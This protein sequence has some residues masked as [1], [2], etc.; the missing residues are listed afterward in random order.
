MS[1]RAG[2]PAR[3]SPSTAPAVW[4]GAADC[5]ALIS[6]TGCG[7]A[8]WLCRWDRPGSERERLR[9]HRVRKAGHGDARNDLFPSP[10]LRPFFRPAEVNRRKTLQR[11]NERK[12]RKA[13]S[14]SSKAFL[15]FCAKPRRKALDAP[16]RSFTTIPMAAMIMRRRTADLAGRRS[17]MRKEWKCRGTSSRRLW[18]K[19]R[20]ASSGAMASR[21]APCCAR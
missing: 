18:S 9:K 3:P 15:S 5:R 14:S 20:T 12:R 8:G 4:H 6:G 19:P 11:I 7:A 21:A 10:F 13:T 17:V 1:F 2:A 16:S